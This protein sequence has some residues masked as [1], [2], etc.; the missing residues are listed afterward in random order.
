MGTKV[1]HLL[2]LLSPSLPIGAYSYS[3]GLEWLVE[4]GQIETAAALQT[5]LAD[6]LVYGSIRIEAAIVVRGYQ[7]VRHASPETLTY[8][9]EW[10]VA[11]RETAELRQQSLQMGRSL[12]QLLATLI[13]ESQLWLDVCEPL[14]LPIATAVAA[15]L[16][17][18]EAR[19]LVQ[20]YLYNWSNNL[21]TAGIRL[22]VLGQ[23]QGQALLL[24]LMP[25]M[26]TQTEVI[27]ALKDPELGCFNL[28]LSLASMAHETQYSRLFRS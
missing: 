9:N 12:G 7:A 11:A 22:G 1:L 20:S 28:G 18:I 14:S 3:E 24:A 23:T 21:M 8:W 4:S 15:A 2:Q 25:I 13:P 6:E 26:E 16:W 5:W 27:M 10:F 17:Q 19:S